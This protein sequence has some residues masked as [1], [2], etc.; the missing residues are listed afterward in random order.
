MKIL[1]IDIGDGTQDILLYDDEKNIENC[2]KMVLPSPSRIFAE[3]VREVTQRRRD[4]F[5]RG[6]IIGGGAFTKALKDHLKYGYR[7]IMTEKTAYTVR[8][9]LDQVKED[10][11]KVIAGESPPDNFDGE[12]LEIMEV[13]PDIIR[14]F[15]SEYNEN[16]SDI[17]VLAIAVQDHG[18]YPKGTSNRRFRLDK[19]REL[20]EKNPMLQSLA[21]REGEVPKY[22]LRMKAAISAAED[23]LPNVKV[24]IMDTAPAAILGCL[25]DLDIRRGDPLLTVNVGNCHTMAALITDGRVCG[26]V[27]HHT[28]LMTPRKIEKLLIDFADGRLTDEEVFEDNGHGAFFLSNPPLFSR[29]KSVAATGPRREIL[30]K[31]GL[32]VHFATP[33]GDMMMTGPVGLV[34]AA[35]AKLKL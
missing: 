34:K 33:A 1:A 25:E 35:K 11:I 24:L 23:Q 30:S 29:I 22:Y 12:T 13:A 8:N 27:E 6:R 3:R 16:L 10:G 17:A 5:I 32:K 31:T 19:M 26:I 9:D 4:L 28:H 20:L 14:R 2:I 15:L 7:V 18:V 21:F